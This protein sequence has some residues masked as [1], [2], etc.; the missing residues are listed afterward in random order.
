MRCF[1]F[2]LQRRLQ[3]SFED[4]D[5]LLVVKLCEGTRK[6][7]IYPTLARVLE[8]VVLLDTCDSTQ[9]PTGTWSRQSSGIRMHQADAQTVSHVFALKHIHIIPLLLI[10][11]TT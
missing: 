4:H 7:G 2:C 5:R 9:V 10:K 11:V 3:R 6:S 8:V 1:R